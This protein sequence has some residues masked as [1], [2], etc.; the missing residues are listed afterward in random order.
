MLFISS[1]PVFLDICG[2]LRQLFFT[3]IALVTLTFLAKIEP[4][5][6]VFYIIKV[7]EESADVIVVGS[8]GRIITCYI[9]DQ[10]PV[11]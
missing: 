8:F 3:V 1:T 7:A 6:F 4:I 2:S 9:Y 5:L 11:L 10:W